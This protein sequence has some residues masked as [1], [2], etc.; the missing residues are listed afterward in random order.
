M[1]ASTFE[2][3]RIGFITSEAGSLKTLGPHWT[4][5][6]LLAVQQINA[7]GGALP[8]RQV[9]VVVTDDETEPDIAYQLAQKLINQDHVVGIVGAPTS[10]ASLEV[11]KVAGPS[12]VPQISGTSTSPLLN[13]L[14]GDGND[15]HPFF[16][17]TVPGDHHQGWVLGSAARGQFNNGDL[18]L[19]CDSMA[20]VYVDNAYGR[21]FAASIRDRF[22]ALGGT[23]AVEV[24]YQDGRPTYTEQVEQL[25]SSRPDCIAMV[26]YVESGGTI[27]REWYSTGGDPEV[28]WLGTDGIR[29]TGFANEAGEHALGVMGS[30]PASDPNRQ[31]LLAFRNAYRTTFNRDPGTLAESVY[32]ATILLLLGIARAGSTD[33]DAIREALFDVSAYAEGEDSFGPGE[34]LGA[35]EKIREGQSIDYEGAGGNVNFLPA[36]GDVVADYEIWMWDGSSFRRQATV[37]V[38]MILDGI[39]M[40]GG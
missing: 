16:F 14:D 28:R 31:E 27:V 3:I 7:T 13:A 4:N 40:G 30:A 2:E 21:P 19:S 6:C 39:G 22:V 34:I 32:D 11:A 38:R 18:D 35:M 26:A 25:I 29:D 36:T 33:G 9:E 1:P 23:I 37:T 20:L 24:P 15:I 5:A 8:G 17:R 10:G 12:S